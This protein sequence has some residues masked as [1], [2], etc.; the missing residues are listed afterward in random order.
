MKDLYSQYLCGHYERAEEFLKASSFNQV[1][2]PF[3]TIEA[4]NEIL[5][6]LRAPMNRIK[7]YDKILGELIELTEAHHVEEKLTEAKDVLRAIK[8]KFKKSESEDE[9]LR[10]HIKSMRDKRRSNMQVRLDGKGWVKASNH[11]ADAFERFL[12]DG[13]G[14]RPLTFDQDRRIFDVK[15]SA[16]EGVNAVMVCKGGL[17]WDMRVKNAALVPRTM[18]V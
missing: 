15:P 17:S 10:K 3:P 8:E 1:V 2:G 7:F 11:Q 6:L 13:A 5:E 4:T 14:K 18:D 16:S 9:E 12:D